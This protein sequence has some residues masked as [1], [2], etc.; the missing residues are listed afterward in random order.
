[1]QDYLGP[2]SGDEASVNEF[3][4]NLHSMYL[5]F[6]LK[7]QFR[8]D[9]HRG[10][11]HWIVKIHYMTNDIADIMV[12]LPAE[13]RDIMRDESTH[14]GVFTCVMRVGDVAVA[15]RHTHEEHEAGVDGCRLAVLLDA[16]VCDCSREYVPHPAPQGDVRYER[17]DSLL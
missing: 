14:L 5:E 7:D 16:C 12:T 9:Y 3:Y 15:H 8:V 11:F 6:V 13:K 17:G 2:L 10:R 1:M 4:K